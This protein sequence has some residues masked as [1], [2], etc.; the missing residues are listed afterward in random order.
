MT[1]CC[2]PRCGAPDGTHCFNCPIRQQA[3]NEL[4]TERGES[5]LQRLLRIARAAQLRKREE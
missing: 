4:Q 1:E 5:P 3:V 2:W